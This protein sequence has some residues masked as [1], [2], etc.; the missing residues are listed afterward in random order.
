MDHGILS[1]P[2]EKLVVYDTQTEKEIAVITNELVNTAA[3][4]I[5]VRL[6]PKG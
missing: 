3:E 1:E 5:V 4:N 6:I 2:Y